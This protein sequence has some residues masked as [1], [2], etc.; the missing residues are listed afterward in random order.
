MAIQEQLIT[1]KMVYIELE[2]SNRSFVDMRNYL[3]A[4]GIQN[5]DFFLALLDP[6]L[7]GVDPRDPNLN[8]SMKSR[9]LNECCRNYWYFLRNVVRIPIQ[10][11]DPT[12][13]AQY[14][15]H[16]GNLAMNFLFV[17]NFN[18]IDILP[19]QNYKT[20]SAVC[21]YLWCFNFGTS[22]SKIMFMHK[23][24]QGSKDNLKTLKDLRTALPSYLQM[25]GSINGEGRKLKIPDTIVELG[26]P[27][28]NNRIVTFPSA[29]TR[30]NAN[31]LGRGATMPLQFYDEFA[32]MPYNQIV[33][34]AA[35]PAFSQAAINAASNN[36]PYGICI[37]TTPGDL[38]TDSGQYCYNMINNATPWC[39]R[40]Y[41][42]TLQQLLEV[43]K[44]NHNSNFFFVQYSYQQLGR[45]PDYFAD[46]VLNLQKN[47]A[48][49]RREVL[50]EWSEVTENKAF[51]EEDLEII[52]GYL[53]DPIDT[54]LLGKYGQ[55]QFQLYS[56]I[57]LSSPPIMGV[58]VSGALMQDASAI[59][60]IDSK[61]TKVVGTLN[62]N[63]ITSDDLADAIY[64]LITRYTPNAV[65]S[66]ERNGEE[67]AIIVCEMV[68]VNF[69]ITNLYIINLLYKGKYYY[70]KTN[71]KPS[72]LF[73]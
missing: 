57:D 50:L 11:G 18:Q 73:C 42:Y 71:Y 15:L 45:G 49:I 69:Y 53:K 24:H 8:I 58:D 31:N 30:E 37:T 33:Y 70:E 61:T 46:Q 39:E 16:R 65:C 72:R 22:N 2:T 67:T 63:Y 9:I 7:A 10:G 44:S 54:I 35:A 32:F 13:G 34:E 40:Y 68:V 56:D 48:T 6:G 4:T 36:A 55:Y 41:D 43:R 47:W 5:N 20:V 52:K 59:T 66:I 28:N 14:K 23:A 62:C 26:H 51:R 27:S 1:P 38:L 3:K 21:R 64:F 60:V 25:D 12:K 17:L 29:R 19:R